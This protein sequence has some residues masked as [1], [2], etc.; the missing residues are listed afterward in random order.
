MAADDRA[1]V[2]SVL[3]RE[4]WGEKRPVARL[5]PFGPLEDRP[6]EVGARRPVEVQ[7]V[8]LLE[9]LLAHVRQEQLVVPEGEPPGIA[10]A[11]GEDLR[12]CTRPHCERV[13]GRDR[14]GAPIRGSRVDAQQLAVQAS[15]ILAALRMIAL[16]Q[17]DPEMTVGAEDQVATEV[18]EAL[19]GQ[20]QDSAPGPC[21][22]VL[23]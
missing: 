3:S 23:G 11:V 14:V 4:G 17:R 16:A 22:R 5:K 10:Q 1:H 2:A 7:Q 15:E 20:R 18:P 9:A 6:A 21:R 8:H 13:S 19:L 12:P